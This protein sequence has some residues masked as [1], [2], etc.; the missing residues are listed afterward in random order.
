[1][2]FK[3]VQKASCTFIAQAHV[4]APMDKNLGV[5]KLGRGM[6]VKARGRTGHLGTPAGVK[7]AKK[8]H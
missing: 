7:R 4:K 6:S 3:G 1:M 5:Q 8:A 2:R